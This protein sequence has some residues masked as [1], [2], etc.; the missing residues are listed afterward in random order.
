[1]SVD[2]TIPHLPVPRTTAPRTAI[3][4]WLTAGERLTEPQRAGEGPH[5]WYKVLWL[6]G[7]DYFSTLGYQPGIALLAAGA[8]SPLATGILVL[9]TLLGAVPVYAQVAGRSY[10]GQGSI[11]MLE[12]LLPE[13][14]GKMF[15]LAL[16]G[17]AATDFVITM[18]LS[19]A[20]AAQHA[21]E[22]PILHPYLGSHRL[23]LTL[24]LLALLGLVFIKGFREAI[25]VAI[26][27]AIPYIALNFI[28]LLVILSLFAFG[29]LRR[30]LDE[31]RERIEQGLRD[32]EQARQDRER[33]EADRLAA[34]QE[35]RREAN[36]ILTR[37]QKVADESRERDLAATREE[38]E[39]IRTRAAADLEAEKQRAIGELRA[40]VADLALRAAGRVVGETMTGDRQRRLVGEFL[41]ETASGSSKG[42]TS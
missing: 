4:R 9:V 6:T 20:D 12:A 36:E 19:A 32:A 25:R 22:N 31:R 13:W 2:Y 15:V 18:T 27:V 35:A 11:A 34:L 23:A 39:R 16:L 10:A 42:R 17:F 28:V 40:E 8:L 7:V 30:I 21:V 33:A 26:L 3:G 14:T 38:L 41:E 37:A 5:P 24:G 1:M 29:P